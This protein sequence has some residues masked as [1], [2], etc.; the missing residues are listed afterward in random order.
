M[1][2]LVVVFRAVVAVGLLVAGAGLAV[3]VAEVAHVGSQTILLGSVVVE[4]AE[5]CLSCPS[6]VRGGRHTGPW[7]L[8]VKLVRA[9]ACHALPGV[10][11]VEL[12]GWEPRGAFGIIVDEVAGGHAGIA[13]SWSILLAPGALGVTR[14]TDRVRSGGNVFSY[15]IIGA[16]YSSIGAVN[17]ACGCSDPFVPIADAR[18]AIGVS[19]AGAAS[20]IG[21]AFD[22]D[23]VGSRHGP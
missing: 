1:S 19:I 14:R 7:Y 21:V 17:M 20:T 5:C 12:W 22:I 18:L 11:C 15:S 2:P 23:S 13:V 9:L 3:G 16:R 10:A 8:V 6:A 4:V